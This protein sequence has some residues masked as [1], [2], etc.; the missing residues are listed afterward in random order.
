MAYKIISIP[1]DEEKGE[2][3]ED[4]LVKFMQE[5]D[6]R[7]MS[8]SFF[9]AGGKSYWSFF[10]EYSPRIKSDPRIEMT[11]EQ[12]ERYERLR[13]WRNTRAEKEGLPPYIIATNK[14]IGIMATMKEVSKAN[15]SDIKGWG[16]A[17]SEKYTND[18]VHVLKQKEQIAAPQQNSVQ[19]N[20]FSNEK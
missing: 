11:A 3:E 13:E 1:F 8:E 14:Q 7:S 10:V 2:F 12:K 9:Q 4:K 15:L 6:V 17:K 16:K 20:I 5:V 18:I 19:Q